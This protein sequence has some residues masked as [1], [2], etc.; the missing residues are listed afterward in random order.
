MK[1]AF[2]Q[3]VGKRI[4]G[5]ICRDNTGAPSAQIF[6]LFD[7]NTYIEIYDSSADSIMCATSSLEKGG[8]E[9]ILMAG[10]PPGEIVHD[11]GT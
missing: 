4:G 5:V 2:D 1:G 3:I 10:S 11:Y 8:R 7:D 6:L 9:E